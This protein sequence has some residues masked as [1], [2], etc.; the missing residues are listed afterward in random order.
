MPAVD[1]DRLAPAL[2]SLREGADRASIVEAH[3]LLCTEAALLAS[4]ARREAAAR[5]CRLMA[6]AASSVRCSVCPR[7]LQLSA[8]DR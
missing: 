6:P 7:E 8:R 2:A 3:R 1:E 5:Y 4:T